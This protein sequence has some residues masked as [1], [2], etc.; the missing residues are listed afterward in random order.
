MR[1]LNVS[2]ALVDQVPGPRP[3]LAVAP[4][5]PVLPWDGI[6]LEGKLPS[7]EEGGVARQLTRVLRLKIQ[8]PQVTFPAAHPRFRRGVVGSSCRRATNSSHEHPS[9]P[10]TETLGSTSVASDNQSNFTR[11]TRSGRHVLAY[12]VPSTPSPLS[13]LGAILPTVMSAMTPACHREEYL[14]PQANMGPGFDCLG[15]AL[16]IWNTCSG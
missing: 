16:D 1:R 14:P 2:G 8:Q 9:G 11:Q 5:L 12:G 7:V 13:G 15:M 4:R 10:S 6:K 3:S